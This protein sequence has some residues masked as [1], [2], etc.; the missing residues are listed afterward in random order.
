M[1]GRPAWRAAAV[2]VFAI[3]IPVFGIPFRGSIPLF[4]GMIALYV[5][6]N[7]GLGLLVASFARTA[8]QAGMLVLL[9]VMPIIVLSGT[10]T[11]FESMPAPLRIVMSL[12]PLSHFVEI[13]YGIILRGVGL[14]TVWDSALSMAVLGLLIFAAGSWRFRRQFR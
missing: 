6:T 14:A 7:A 9:L 13:G 4:F 2:S 10:W 11:P 3:M 12:S 1:S 8:A 5:A